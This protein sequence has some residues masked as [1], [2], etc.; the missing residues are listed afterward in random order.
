MSEGTRLP[1]SNQKGSVGLPRPGSKPV[2][3]RLRSQNGG[4]YGRL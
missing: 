2:V 1:F 4:L 3:M